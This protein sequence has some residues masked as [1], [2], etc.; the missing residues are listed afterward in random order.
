[1]ILIGLAVLFAFYVYCAFKKVEDERKWKNNVMEL[2]IKLEQRTAVSGV[3]DVRRL[4]NSVLEDMKASFPQISAKYE[5]SE[6]GDVHMIEIEPAEMLHTEEFIQFQIKWTD[7]LH[8]LYRYATLIFLN[9][10][11]VC[12]VQNPA[13]TIK[14]MNQHA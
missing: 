11:S 4:V 12:R 7:E 2:L 14:G 3:A 8:R 10:E 9:E 13:I 6:I 5:Y 1:M